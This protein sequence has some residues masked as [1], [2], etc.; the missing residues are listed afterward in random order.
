MK[1]AQFSAGWAD[2]EIRVITIYD[3]FYNQ[4]CAAG[5]IL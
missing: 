3:Y 5:R 1:V 2:G 4:G